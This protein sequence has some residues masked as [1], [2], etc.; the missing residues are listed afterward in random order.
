MGLG[1]IVRQFLQWGS[2]LQRC[3]AALVSYCSRTRQRN[4]RNG[5]QTV[6]GVAPELLI[7]VS[8]TVTYLQISSIPHK[9]TVN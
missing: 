5:T 1:I 8:C 4:H 6:E 7:C 2:Q 9:C 3:S